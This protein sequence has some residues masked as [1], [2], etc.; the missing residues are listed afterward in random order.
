MLEPVPVDAVSEHEDRSIGEKGEGGEVALLHE[1]EPVGGG[2]AV[3]REGDPGRGSW[4]QGVV[5]LQGEASAQGG[6]RRGWR[7]HEEAWL[8][9]R[10]AEA[11]DVNYVAASRERVSRATELV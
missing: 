6:N 4:E 5:V 1:G 3:G 8:I 7:A 9:E 10:I 2:F 11:P